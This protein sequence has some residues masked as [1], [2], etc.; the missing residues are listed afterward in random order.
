MIH[1]KAVI[2][3][4]TVTAHFILYKIHI[5]EC[6]KCCAYGQWDSKEGQKDDST[7]MY[8]CH[9]FLHTST[10]IIFCLQIWK[11]HLHYFKE[12]SSHP[13][14]KFPQELYE[15]KTLP[16]VLMQ[17]QTEPKGHKLCIHYEMSS[18]QSKACC[19]W[20]KILVGWTELLF[21][22]ESSSCKLLLAE[23]AIFCFLSSA[24]CFPN[25]VTAAQR[26]LLVLLQPSLLF[27]GNTHV[28]H[29]ST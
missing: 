27:I 17:L 26:R 8:H 24:D 12:K 22:S 4:H 13:E 14:H 10:R 23:L 19:C 28:T 20:S 11:V 9:L 6:H 25:A 16:K 3:W 29:F 7:L 5:P 21:C 1:W 2:V 18:C 15:T